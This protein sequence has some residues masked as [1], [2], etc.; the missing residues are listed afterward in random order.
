MSYFPG[1]GAGFGGFNG[2]YAP[3][4]AGYGSYGGFG[5]YPGYGGAFNSWGN[6]AASFAGY[7]NG[8]GFNSVA[9]VPS[10]NHTYEEVPFQRQVTEFQPVTHNIQDSY[11]VENVQYNLPRTQLEPTMQMV[12]A[13]GYEPR[14]YVDQMNQQIVH[15]P[16]SP[17]SM[18][19]KSGML[20]NQ[21]FAQTPFGPYPLQGQF[22]APGP[23]GPGSYAGLPPQGQQ[24]GG[25]RSHVAQ[26]S[27]QPPQQQSF[28]GNPNP[29]FGQSQAPGIKSTRDNYDSL[30]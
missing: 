25:I 26:N 30:Q 5:G 17:V 12:P 23:F 6:P 1:Y 22:G 20:P 24:P 21:S 14:T 3:S 19:K 7:N 9:A 18:M 16:Y 15:P 11:T 29:L 10:Q 27:Y 8:Y 4:F 28:A 13:V 2:G